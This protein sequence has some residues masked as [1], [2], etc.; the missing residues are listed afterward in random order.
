VQSW[1]CPTDADL[2]RFHEARPGINRAR[3]QVLLILVTVALLTVPGMKLS[4]VLLICGHLV[5][6]LVADRVLRDST[7][8]VVS[9]LLVVQGFQVLLTVSVGATGGV[10]SPYLC[11]LTIPVTMLAAR[12]RRAVV[13]AALGVA[14]LM[15]AATCLVAAYFADPPTFA[16]S[17]YPMAVLGL[18]C[19][20]GS[21]ALNLQSAEIES[22]LAALTDPLT[23]LLNR[24]ALLAD[25]EDAA[26]QAG[27]ASTMLGLLLLDLDHF[28]TI[29]DRYGHPI[30]DDVLRNVA[31][32]VLATVGRSDRVY[33]VGGEEIVVLLTGTDTGESFDVA[34]RIR[35]AIALRP[36]AEVAVSVS[37]GVAVAQARGALWR[38]VFAEADRALYQAKAAGRNRVVLAAADTAGDV[39][40]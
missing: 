5:M 22:R 40:A 39:A 7:P 23:G 15:G 35:V 27:E 17:A 10:H 12:Y 30:G 2:R 13:I 33:R 9:G 6:A 34:E 32:I 11:W 3:R 4:W 21:V 8:T 25:F 1:L 16:P 24:K 31:Q 14:A 26:G 28:K 29:N 18:G 36:I 20:L 38:D 19:A 37:A